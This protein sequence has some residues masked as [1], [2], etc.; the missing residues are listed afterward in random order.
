MHDQD[1][2]LLR[3]YVEHDS[4]A[5]FGGLVERHLDFVYA[6]CLREVG[7]SALAED[8]TQVVFLLLARKASILSPEVV[9]SGWLFQTARFAAKNARR[10]EERWHQRTR[11]AVET[12]G[13][14]ENSVATRDA[15]WTQL[16][17][18]L[19]EG[20]LMLNEVERNAVLLR[21]FEDRTLKETADVLGLS[22]EAA[23]KRVTRAIEKLRSHFAGRG[24]ALSMTSLA[25]LLTA[26][27]V[28]A[29]PLSHA[30]FAQVILSSPT[31]SSSTNVVLKGVSTG[32]RAKVPKQWPHSLSVG[33]GAVAAMTLCG[34]VGAVLLS[35]WHGHK[36]LRA[37][38]L[39][40]APVVAPSQQQS[41]TTI[42]P[43]TTA[44]NT[45][46]QI[47]G[48]AAVQRPSTPSG[49]LGATNTKETAK[50]KKTSTVVA[51]LSAG[52]LL[53]VSAL[54]DDINARVKS[55]DPGAH[56]ITVVE[57]QEDYVFTVTDSTQFVNAQGDVLA[58]GLKRGK[59]DTLAIGVKSGALKAGTRLSINFQK[60][61]DSRLAAIV[62]LRDKNRETK[63]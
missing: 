20:L 25:V 35:Q 18:H 4:Q 7:N 36:S 29:T 17:P 56:T 33:K 39:P 55:V 24:V 34:I 45:A 19:H 38:P 31:L 63:Q 57:R 1:W 12:I 54:A 32:A 10:R 15:I 3:E 21:Y 50:M 30:A 44:S 58:T 51:A 52:A 61:G 9:L 60:Q 14:E 53:S 11:R 37:P 46:R 23:R 59:D 5:A 26:H 49:T 28:R 47:S 40:T 6:T 43:P 2:Q 13:E 41:Q 62:K 42:A 16:E 8:V 27:T 48:P 22:E